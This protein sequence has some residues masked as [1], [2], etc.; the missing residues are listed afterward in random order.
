MLMVVGIIKP[1]KADPPG[2]GNF[3]LC[4][5]IPGCY[6]Y[7]AVPCIIPDI[8]GTCFTCTECQGN[9]DATSCDNDATFNPTCTGCH[10]QGGRCCTT[11][12]NTGETCNNNEIC[13]NLDGTYFYTFSII[14]GFG[15]FGTVAP[16]T[17]AL[18]GGG[19]GFLA[20]P[21]VTLGGG[22]VIPATALT[23]I[24]IM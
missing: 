5:T 11:C 6:I 19:L 8:P 3:A 15:L 12:T 14:G 9:Y 10:D 18:F 22:G 16:S 20:Q 1:V 4:A 23:V 7:D 13:R 2:G 17:P 24:F 21:G